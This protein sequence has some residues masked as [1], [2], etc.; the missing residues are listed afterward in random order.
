MSSVLAIIR[1]KANNATRRVHNLDATHRWTAVFPGHTI[2]L[3]AVSKRPIPR[4]H[5]HLSYDKGGY[6]EQT[7]ENGSYPEGGECVW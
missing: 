1:E 2:Y 4:I 7:L 5:H 6:L 3:H